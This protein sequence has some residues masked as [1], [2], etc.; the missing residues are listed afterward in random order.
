[1]KKPTF[2]KDQTQNENY[3]PNNDSFLVSPGNSLQFAK[4]LNLLADKICNEIEVR[5]AK[6]EAK[7][8]EIERKTEENYRDS[9]RQTLTRR[10]FFEKIEENNCN[11]LKNSSNSLQISKLEGRIEQIEAEF[12]EFR[13]EVFLKNSQ[14]SLNFDSFQ[15]SFSSDFE[16]INKK[17]NSFFLAIKE[18]IEKKLT[19][20]QFFK[21][22]KRETQENKE[23][24]TK[25]EDDLVRVLLNIKEID[26]FLAY[27]KRNLYSNPEKTKRER[28]S[29]HNI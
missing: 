19:N 22:I 26:C 9:T 3:D 2:T 16:A 17:M 13:N 18:E 4:I 29:F 5:L 6:I 21:E 23:I 1:M 8:E 27:T 15:Q 10:S 24:V 12:S 20:S 7:L 25:L 28:R 14:I 11:C